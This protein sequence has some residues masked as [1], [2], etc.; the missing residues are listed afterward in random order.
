MEE[1][2][3][4]LT[5]EELDSFSSEDSYQTYLKD[6]KQYKV[7][8]KEE[9][10]EIANH[11]L[12]YKDLKSKEILISSNLRL[13]LS[14]AW[15]YTNRIK[16]FQILDVIQEGNLGLMRAVETYNPAEGAFSTYATHWI[17]NSIARSIDEKEK[18]IRKPTHLEEM[19]RKYNY[20]LAEYEQKKDVLLTDEEICAKLNISQW[21][22]ENIRK[23]FKQKV[24]SLNSLV[25][26]EE[27]TA[28]ENFISDNNDIMD[29]TINDI[30]DYDLGVV[31]KEILSPSEYYV[32]YN[33]YFTK[34]RL[35]L[36]QISTLYNLTREAVRLIEIKSLRKIKPLM[37]GTQKIFSDKL[38]EIKI[39][40]GINYS[41]L[42]LEPITFDQIIRY[43]YVKDKL[44]TLED[45]LYKLKYFSKYHI[46]DY[47]TYLGLTKEEYGKLNNSLKEKICRVDENS[48]LQYKNQ[49][50][51]EY[52]KK[53][54]YLITR[55]EIDNNL[56]LKRCLKSS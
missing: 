4:L 51:K 40:E 43:Y 33:R 55:E 9:Q 53:I 38:R 49:M 3:E 2:I 7:L 18:L 39:R 11:Y 27:D 47:A 32:I 21:L 28:L 5:D 36:E 46:P 52:G 24:V 1:K 17:K 23:S 29:Q 25:Y 37:M 6:I 42:I 48:Y 35:K 12:Q 45:T 22:L 41:K 15:K 30:Y 31:I 54:L 14:I 26:E 56:T 10:K 50:V 8:T 34:N 16:N 44:T 19:I 20:L 13:V